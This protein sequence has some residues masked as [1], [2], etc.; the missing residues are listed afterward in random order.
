MNFTATSTSKLARK[1]VYVTAEQSVGIAERSGS[2]NVSTYL[3]NQEECY[4]MTLACAKLVLADVLQ[5]AGAS[6]AERSLIISRIY[7]AVAPSDGDLYEYTSMMRDYPPSLYVKAEKLSEIL[8][9]MD[10]P[11]GGSRDGWVEAISIMCS[12]MFPMIMMLA[13]DAKAGI[14][15]GTA[16]THQ[17]T[18]T[19]EEV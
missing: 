15:V 14:S 2:G 7:D 17:Y 16:N 19:S 8:Y 1:H 6:E 9:G 3:R 5:G 13:C 18:T 4:S 10:H 12:A 11:V